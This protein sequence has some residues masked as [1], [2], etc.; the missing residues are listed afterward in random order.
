MTDGSDKSQWRAWVFTRNNYSEV[1]EQAVKQLSQL[2]TAWAY[3]RE[4]G[5]KGTPHLQGFLMLKCGMS[6]KALSKRL[7]SFWLEPK[8]KHSTF[9]QTWDYCF[10]GAQTKAEWLE[11][12]SSG[13]NFGVDASC[14]Q[15]GECPLGQEQKG[16]RGAEYYAKNLA[17]ARTD[18]QSMDP[19][20]QFEIRKFQE[21]ARLIESTVK[22]NALEPMLEAPAAWVEFHCGVARAGKTT[23]V[24]TIPG[25]VFVWKAGTGWNNYEWQD[26]V[27]FEDVDASQAPSMAE[28]KTMCDPRVF[29]VRA[30]YSSVY[31]RPRRLIFTTNEPS[32][33]AVWPQATGEHLRALEDRMTVHV[34][35]HR[36]FLDKLK[37]HRNP[38]WRMP[39]TLEDDTEEPWPSD[40]MIVEGF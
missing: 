17:L 8:L 34:W 10:K 13:P 21:A 14:E 6:H 32:I 18:P 29:Q 15:W 2:S 38:D 24:D 20:A 31:V 11:S 28:V 1:D 7:P 5:E 37:K 39:E 16:K 40:E 26:T 23:Y 35:K 27:V 9:R 30:L 22:R 4:I 36:Y 33:A 3:G 19:Q 12:G 25:E